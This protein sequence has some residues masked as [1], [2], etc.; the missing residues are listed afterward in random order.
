M[1]SHYGSTALDALNFAHGQISPMLG[2]VSEFGRFRD[3][4]WGTNS[5]FDI[6]D[7]F[8]GQQVRRGIQGVM[9][10]GAGT[11]A[12]SALGFNP[13]FV[14]G[15][16][17]GESAPPHF[18]RVHSAIAD[19]GATGFA[20]PQIGDITQAL[21]FAREKLAAGLLGPR[22]QDMEFGTGIRKGL[23]YGSEAAQRLLALARLSTGLGH[24][25]GDFVNSLL[26]SNPNVTVRL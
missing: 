25:Q 18:W 20:P 2:G 21:Q 9:P 13:S 26:S 16:G 17:T 12:L 23:G 3:P 24:G 14:A 22:A 7:L 11:G 1:P 4:F 10:V 6:N 8:Q 5:V 19:K 15:L